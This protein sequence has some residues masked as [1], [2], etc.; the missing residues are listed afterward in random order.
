VEQPLG[1][2]VWK[3]HLDGREGKSEWADRAN[4]DSEVSEGSG[5]SVSTLEDEEPEAECD[6]AS[7]R[8]GQLRCPVGSDMAKGA[9]V[10]QVRS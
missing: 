9:V 8:Y 7:R 2:L 10:V 4:R 3:G 5:A 1:R 6:A